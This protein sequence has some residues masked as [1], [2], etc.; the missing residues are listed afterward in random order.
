M[1]FNNSRIQAY[2]RCPRFYYYRFIENL[3]PNREAVPL[4]VGRAVHRGL[5][6]H[7]LGLGRAEVGAQ[8]S[9]AFDESRGQHSWLQAE[10]DELKQQE[11]YSKQILVWYTD[12]YASEAWTP[13]APEVR[14]SVP[15]GSHVFFF[16]ADGVVSWR[17][18]PWLLETK[19]TSQLGSTFFRKFFMDAQPKLYIYA[20]GVHMNMA[21]KGVIIN[22]IKKA[23]NLDKV[24]FAREVIMPTDSQIKECVDQT[25]RQADI[26]EGLTN[27]GDREAFL[28]H[29]GECIRYNRTCD[30]FEMCQ[31][32]VIDQAALF[33]Q[34]E[35]DYT[36]LEEDT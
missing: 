3:V 10:L 6:A 1:H 14:G 34:R 29:F 15:M 4:L 13:L 36:E 16:Q 17:G 19:T 20:I 18:Y 23:R 27:F 11:A 35:P 9:A 26:I 7:Y 25:I 30:Y 12:H 31:G 33:K 28:M 2:H 5:A 21:P 24:E 22:A 32:I 8:V